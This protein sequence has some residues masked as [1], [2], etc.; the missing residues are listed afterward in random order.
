[1]H[2]P[3]VNNRI[4]PFLQQCD[5]DE[6]LCPAPS[7]LGLVHS[8][9]ST[10]PT[11]FVSLF[12]ILRWVSPLLFIGILQDIAAGIGTSNSL[13]AASIVSLNP[14]SFGSMKNIPHNSLAFSSFGFSIIHLC[15]AFFFTASD[16]NFHVSGHTSAGLEVVC[17][18][19][20]LSLDHVYP[21]GSLSFNRKNLVL[22]IHVPV[23]FILSPIKH[24]MM[25][26][27]IVLVTSMY[28]SGI[29]NDSSFGMYFLTLGAT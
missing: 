26:I 2:K 27:Y 20:S 8:S 9:A 5:P 4:R 12:P 24:P 1:M 15:F 19:V 14:S 28:F 18:L 13:R 16:I 29:G 6:I 3:T 22:S 21:S 25:C 11:Y 10:T 17:F 23:I 7:C